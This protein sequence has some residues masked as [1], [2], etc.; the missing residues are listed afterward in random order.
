ME[1]KVGYVVWATGWKPYDANR[2]ETYGFGN[3]PDVITN[4]MME[5]L[6]SWT[7][8]TQGKILRPSDGEAPETVAFVR[9][10]VLPFLAEMPGLVVPVIE[11]PDTVALAPAPCT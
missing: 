5:R 2:L 1:L 3:Y 4:V 8:P 7:G 6:A 11:P 9:S 10:T